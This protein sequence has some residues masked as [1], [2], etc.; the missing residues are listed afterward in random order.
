MA[1]GAAVAPTALSRRRR[2]GGR[3]NVEK[4]VAWTSRHAAN[5]RVQIPRGP[6]GSTGWHAAQIISL[7]ASSTVG[8]QRT[9]A[10]VTILTTLFT[11]AVS[12]VKV[13]TDVATVFGALG[14]AVTGAVVVC[15]GSSIWTDA[16][17]RL[18]QPVDRVKR[19]VG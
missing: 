7:A 11:L 12:V 4:S 18:A 3:H 14:L 10:N 2:W 15:H 19:G 5:F 13:V 8:S 1:N 17:C 9:N 6:L 16:P